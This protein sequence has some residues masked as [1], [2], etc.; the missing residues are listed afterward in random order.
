MTKFEREKWTGIQL[1]VFQMS[2]LMDMRILSQID[3]WQCMNIG[4]VFKVCFS[5]V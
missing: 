2:H 4:I 1:C 5:D 3:S